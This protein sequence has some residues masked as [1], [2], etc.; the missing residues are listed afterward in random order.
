[1]RLCLA[2]LLLVSP[3]E[4]A[5]VSGKIAAPDGTSQKRL[6]TKLYGTEAVAGHKDP[7]PTL[8]VVWLEGVAPAKVESKSAVIRQE[9]LEFRP[10]ALAVGAG[11]KVEFPNE[12]DL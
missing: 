5:S 8:A 10:R 4:G 3:Q 7:D 1:M 12:D 6:R 2:L 11:S 9:G